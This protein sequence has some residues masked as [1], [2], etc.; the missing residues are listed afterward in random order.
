LCLV[1]E[2]HGNRT[3]HGIDRAS[4]SRRVTSGAGGQRR[5][6]LAVEERVLSESQALS[7][8]SGLLQFK[9]HLQADAVP[10]VYLLMPERLA[11]PEYCRCTPACLVLFF[12]NPGGPNGAL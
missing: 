11:V 7:W 12:K 5:R 9:L 3:R 2:A 8:L 10:E 1:A 6:S 4:R